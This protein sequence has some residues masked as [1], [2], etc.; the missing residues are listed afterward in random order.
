MNEA[1]EN[2]AP[3]LPEME[4]K[5]EET[6]IQELEQ[7]ADRSFE[8]ALGLPLQTEEV[9]ESRAAAVELGKAPPPQGSPTPTEQPNQVPPQQQP[10]FSQNEVKSNDEVRYQHWQSKA[11]KL[12]N[13][14]KEMNEYAPMVD[15]LRNNPEAVKQIDTAKHTA[16]GQAPEGGEEFPPPPERPQAPLGFTQEDALNDP[17][18]ESAR[19]VQE[20]EQ[21]REDM[22][23]YSNLAHQYETQKMRD[24]YETRIDKLEKLE[25]QRKQGRQQVEEMNRIREFVGKRYGMQPQEAEQFIQTMN[26]PSSINMDDLVGYYKFKQSTGDQQF[27]GT[28]PAQAPPAPPPPSAPPVNNQ[29]SPEFQQMQRAQSVPTPM[30]VQTAAPSQHNAPKSFMDVLIDDNNKQ[31]IL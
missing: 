12:E 24:E 29:P 13:Q 27:R 16:E 11:A 30:G 15:Y 26:S 31:N 19:Y 1:R 20:H 7:K 9:I 18:S 10:D 6:R 4:Q 5:L 23:T 28:P 14:L 21:W 17:N 25:L 2:S 8:A 3:D 22:Q